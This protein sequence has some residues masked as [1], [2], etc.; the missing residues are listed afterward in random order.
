MLLSDYYNKGKDGKGIPNSPN[1]NPALLFLLFFG[2]FYHDFGPQNLSLTDFSD[3][4]HGFGAE[5]PRA[6]VGWLYYWLLM[7][8]AT[9]PETTGEVQQ[10]SY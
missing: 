10:T 9:F 8:G 4:G 6:D 1:T 2:H 7:K 3:F 5:Y